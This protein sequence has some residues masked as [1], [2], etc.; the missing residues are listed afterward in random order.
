MR[1]KDIAT[2]VLRMYMSAVVGNASEAPFMANKNVRGSESDGV[3][4]NCSVTT[5]ASFKLGLSFES[6]FLSESVDN[7]KL[8][9]SED[10]GS[11]VILKKG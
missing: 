9:S 8:G 2:R 5:R 1:V 10:K 7:R 3:N 4:G 6:L 11:F